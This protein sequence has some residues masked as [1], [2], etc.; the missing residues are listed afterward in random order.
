PSS[1]VPSTRPCTARRDIPLSRSLRQSSRDWKQRRSASLIFQLVK[2]LWGSGKSS[3][4]R[5]W[6][7]R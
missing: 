2:D 1:L 5:L 3:M 4:K 6:G 7:A